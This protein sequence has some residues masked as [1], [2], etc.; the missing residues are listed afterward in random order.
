MATYKQIIEGL[1][2]LAKHDKDGFEGHL[3]GADHD[4]VYGHQASMLN[5]MSDEDRAKLNE[6]G[7]HFDEDNGWSHFC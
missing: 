7:W 5:K 1:T 6:L 4:I 2:I 3:G